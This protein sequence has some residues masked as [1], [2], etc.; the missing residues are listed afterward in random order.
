MKTKERK[1]KVRFR[2]AY[3]A[4][5]VRIVADAAIAT[6]GLG[7]GRLIPLVI[8]DTSERPDIDE[9]VRVHVHLSP[10]DASCQWGRLPKNKDAIAL[11]IDFIRP[12]EMLIII[13]FD[14][15]RQGVLVDQVLRGRGL[16]IQPGRPGDRLVTTMGSPRVLVEVGQL[17]FD[18]KWN[19]L[20]LK[21]V[22]TRFRKEGLSRRDARTAARDFIEEFRRFGALRVPRS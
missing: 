18:D 10:G 11:F 19:Q 15:A 9:L 22:E 3:E 16:Y 12:V 14:I 20:Y 17:G 4:R 6:Q 1:I 5:P 2:T 7:E 21:A 13:E 8:L